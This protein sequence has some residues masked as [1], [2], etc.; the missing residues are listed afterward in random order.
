MHIVNTYFRA[1]TIIEMEKILK[2]PL[3]SAIALLVYMPFH[4]F[5]AQWL[6]TFTGSIEVWKGAKDVFLLLALTLTYGLLIYK[7]QF[8]Q[9]YFWVLTLCSFIYFLIHL[10]VWWAN[11]GI[12]TQA[13]LLGT[14]YNCRLFG[15]ILLA[16][17]AMMLWPGK[18]PLKKAFKIALAVSSVIALLGIIQFALPK[19]VLTHFGYS[20]DRGVKPAFFIDDKADLP[21]IM[22]TIR[23]PNS[24]GAFLILPIAVLALAWTRL[25]KARML[26]GGLLLLHVWALLLTFSRSAWLGTIAAVLLALGWTYR[27]K[28]LSFTKKY[29]VFI[30]VGIVLLGVGTYVL[31]DQYFVQNVVFHSDEN[32]QLADPNELR[33][34]FYQQTA[35]MIAERPFGHGPG[36]AGLVSIQTEKV[37]LT[38]NYFLQI[39]Y[40]VGIQGLALLL[41]L[42]A[43]VCKILYD[44]KNIYSTILLASLVGI[45]VCAM[46]L[47]AWS[48]E[49]V[50]AQWWLLAG[51]ATGTKLV[52][53]FYH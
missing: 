4:V 34:N 22:S 26:I 20:I 29:A 42:M 11:P 47:H 24:L 14:A 25:N 31:R 39:A 53:K 23:D 12:D 7:K 49:A 1:D 30:A 17:G 21:R 27:E 43:F 19:D 10:T 35:D 33:A 13:A 6:S 8:K 44:R 46:L 18:F 48:N 37:V 15:Y 32:T 16:W 36:T 9:R 51:I 28:V 41:A 50:A 2:L 52:Q 5:I 40:E 38:E 45:T 3:Y